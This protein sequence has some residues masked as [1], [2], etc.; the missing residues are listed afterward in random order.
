VIVAR[1]SSTQI[2]SR[3]DDRGHAS[4]DRVAD[5]VVVITLRGEIGEPWAATLAA[6]VASELKRST[7]MNMF[8]D[9]EALESYHAM[10]RKLST[11]ALLQNR[12][13][14]SSLHAIVRSR[15]VSMGVSVANL[16]LGGLIVTYRERQ[17]FE[18]ALEAALMR[19]S[20]P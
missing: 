6:T 17:S 20:R 13:H 5:H 11:D 14:I 1:T 8:W 18:S 3:S 15:V 4:I 9:L 10:I 16:A 12:K 7:H 19:S 2:F